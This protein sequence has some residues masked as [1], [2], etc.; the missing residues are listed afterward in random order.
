MFSHVPIAL[1]RV[2][3]RSAALALLGLFAGGV[4]FLV[5]APSLQRLP[6]E[7]YVP[8]WQALN[9]D[10]G[11]AVPPSLLT[12]MA[13]IGI[14]A[15]LSRG[16]GRVTPAFT[17]AALVLLVLEAVV[18]L[19]Q[20]DGLNRLADSWE[21]GRLPADWAD[22][23]QTWLSWHNVRTVLALAAFGSLLIAHAADNVNA[24][25]RQKGGWR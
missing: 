14:A 15:W 12:C 23:R 24:E 5:I 16:R 19:T 4:T 25:A 11:R 2:G 6:G 3:A 22:V 10:Y 21:P 8:Y 18:T 7:A 20:M 1:L 17:V 9:V 13:L